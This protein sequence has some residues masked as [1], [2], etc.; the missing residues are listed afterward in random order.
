VEPAVPVVVTVAVLA[1][2][3]GGI[4]AAAAVASVPAEW[5]LPVAVC[6]GLAASRALAAHTV[7]RL[8][9]ITGDVLGALV[10]T[11]TAACLVVTTMG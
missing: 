1:A 10:E 4:F 5:I 3:V 9:G 6:A 11:G 7:R 2:T 8:G